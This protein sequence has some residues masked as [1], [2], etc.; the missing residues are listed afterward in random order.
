MHLDLRG[1]E[2]EPD[3][4]LLRLGEQLQLVLGGRVR[5]VMLVV[6]RMAR[7]MPM[8]GALLVRIVSMIRRKMHRQVM[9]VEDEQE[10]GCGSNQPLAQPDSPNPWEHVRA[11]SGQIRAKVQ[12][13]SDAMRR[14]FDWN[15]TISAP[16]PGCVPSADR[17]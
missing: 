16:A 9:D 13:P 12:A 2:I 14:T 7:I 1:Q 8:L 5:N 4:V 3:Q 15:S 10:G 6:A 11:E 17:V